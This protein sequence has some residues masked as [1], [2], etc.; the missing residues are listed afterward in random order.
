MIKN[1]DWPR[2]LARVS[3]RNVWT[4]HVSNHWINTRKPT[5]Q[6]H[7]RQYY[8]DGRKIIS[9]ITSR[10]KWNGS[11]KMET[12]TRLKTRWSW[13]TNQHPWLGFL[14][15]CTRERWVCKW[16]LRWISIAILRPKCRSRATSWHRV[17]L[18]ELTI[19]Y[20]FL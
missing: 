11:K 13:P 20:I 6:S 16:S 9:Q 8:I 1:H 7:M 3:V 14:K 10:E 19:N 4:K 5:E 18:I 17:G 12:P 15:R 2:L